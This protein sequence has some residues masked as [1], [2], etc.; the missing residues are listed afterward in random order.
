[1]FTFQQLIMHYIII[2]LHYKLSASV[3]TVCLL[4]K[5][6][7]IGANMSSARLVVNAETDSDDEIPDELKQ[8][9]VD[10]KTGEPPNSRFI[11]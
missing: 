1:M 11:Y 5:V 6:S 4:I 9:T 8:D 2:N 7:G 3:K 10:E